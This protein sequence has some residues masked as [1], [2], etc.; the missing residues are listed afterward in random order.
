MKELL[1]YIGVKLYGPC[2]GFFKGTWSD[3]SEKTI[4]SLGVTSRGKGWVVAEDKDEPDNYSG[5]VV[6]TFDSAEE[7]IH[8]LDIW[9]YKIED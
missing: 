4:L 5:V 7:M 3:S 6:A 2:N 1:K 8:F 9:R